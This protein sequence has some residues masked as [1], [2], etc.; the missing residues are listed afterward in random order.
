MDIISHVLFAFL[1]ARQKE[2]SLPLLLGAVL[3]DIDRFYSYPMRNYR[4]A[5]SRTFFQELPFLSLM[6]IIGILI[7]EPLFSL[8]I[9]SHFLLDFLV[10][11]SRVFY[12]FYKK[13]VNFNL[14]LRFKVLIGGIIWAIGLAYM[15]SWI[16]I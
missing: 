14:P 16:S 7:G 15:V 2:L 1:L 9:I 6:L 13:P 11:E 3:P 10:G 5:K 8:G 4:G 12:P